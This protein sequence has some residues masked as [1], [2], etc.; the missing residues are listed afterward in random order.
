MVTPIIPQSS[1]DLQFHG[2]PSGIPNPYKTPTRKNGPTYPPPSTE[3]PVSRANTAS[4]LVSNSTPNFRSRTDNNGPV[5]GS[6]HKYNVNGKTGGVTQTSSPDYVHKAPSGSVHA[7]YGRS[8]GRHTSS[9]H[10]YPEAL[11]TTSGNTPSGKRRSSANHDEHNIPPGKKP[12]EADR[13]AQAFQESRRSESQNSP[14][15]FHSSQSQMR[16]SAL[17]GHT[18]GGRQSRKRNNKS[19][20]G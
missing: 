5:L 11:S 9:Q 19:K 20:M 10:G 13:S 2:A 4:R 1:R 7:T 12:R 6:L 18:P 16:S 14:G 15:V 8:K 17:T 3:R